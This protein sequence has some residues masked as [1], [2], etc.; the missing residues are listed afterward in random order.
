MSFLDQNLAA[1]AAVDPGLADVVRNMALPPG[2]EAVTG[3]DGTRTFCRRFDAPGGPVGVRQIEWLGGT[4]MPRAAADAI[5]STLDPT[6]GGTGGNG[7]GLSIGAGYDWRAFVARLSPMQCLFVYEP[8]ADLRL[9]LEVCDLSDLLADRRIVLLSGTADAAGAALARLLT[10]EIGLEAPTVLHPLPSLDRPSAEAGPGER[11]NRLLA[12]GEAIVRAAVGHRQG[13]VAALTARVAAAVHAASPAPPG[14]GARP[15]GL[16]VT[17]RYPQER[18]LHAALARA[19]VAPLCIDRHRS[20]SLAFRFRAL[21]EHLEMAGPGKAA[22]VWSD[23]FRGPLACV[24][25]EVPVV[26]WVPPLAGPG[27]WDHVPAPAAFG[28]CD[29]IV[30][31]AG[32]HRDRLVGRGLPAGQIEVRPIGPIAAVVRASSPVALRH[33]VAVIGDLPCVSAEALGLILPTHQAVYAAARCILEGE[34]LTAHPGAAAD[35][36]R[37]AFGRANVTPAQQADPALREPMLRLVRDVLI[38]AVPVVALARALAAAQVPVTLIGDWPDLETPA[39]DGRF[40]RIGFEGAAGAWDEVAVLAHLSPAGTV[41]PLVW[42]A[43]AAGVAVAA[44]EHP[45]DAEAGALPALLR[46][47][48]EYVHPRPGQFLTAVK[49][50]LRDAGQR[51]RVAAAALAR[52]QASR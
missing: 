35:V 12:A 7:L 19:G 24:P 37:R 23:L 40:R 32:D 15:L 6:A 38:P 46:P 1:L 5:V 16:A 50:L 41:S 33:R 3:T 29:R 10:E 20:A 36:L 14:G 8:S 17:P 48:A 13:Q 49:A 9:A 27:Y 39:G 34:F 28:P 30:V 45:A 47:D 21:A 25:P 42:N 2:S 51:Q 11:R 52:L 31:H 18:P 44:P 43:V 26:T 22:E 4:S